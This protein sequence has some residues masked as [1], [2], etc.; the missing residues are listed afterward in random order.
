MSRPDLVSSPRAT[1]ISIS[2]SLSLSLSLASERCS[3]CFWVGGKCS[4]NATLTDA[5][6]S[7][8]SRV[9]APFPGELVVPPE[10]GADS[11]RGNCVR[12]CVCVCVCAPAHPPESELRPVP[13]GVRTLMRKVTQQQARRFLLRWAKPVVGGSHQMELDV[14][15][16]RER[17][18]E[19]NSENTTSEIKQYRVS[20]VFSW[21]WDALLSLSKLK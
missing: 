7:G 1:I 9:P 8:L 16:E 6:V 4:K 12:V 18:R 19:R 3:A 2:L 15:R 20:K 5:W 14:E 17:A 21:L 13:C 10:S 11:F